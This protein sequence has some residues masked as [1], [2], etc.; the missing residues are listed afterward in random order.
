MKIRAILKAD[1][2]DM[3]VAERRIE[4]QR[5]YRRRDNRKKAVEEQTLKLDIDNLRGVLDNPATLYFL[6]AI[7]QGVQ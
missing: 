4:N 5:R 7:L 6:Q 1:A 3:S 2:M